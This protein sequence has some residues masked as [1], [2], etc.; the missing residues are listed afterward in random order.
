MLIGIE[1]VA[2]FDK[3]FRLYHEGDLPCAITKLIIHDNFETISDLANNWNRWS[4]YLP[5]RSA[6]KV[7][8]RL[9]KHEVGWGKEQK[10]RFINLV[11]KID[12]SRLSKT[13]EGLE[14][15]I[16]LPKYHCAFYNSD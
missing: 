2:I 3:N 10:K 5:F 1:D 8:V 15:W 12:Y 4:R 16:Q 11:I 7:N 13:T 9:S 6:H 14:C